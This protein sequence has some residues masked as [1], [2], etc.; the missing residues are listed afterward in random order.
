M[1][2]EEKNSIIGTK[3]IIVGISTIPYTVKEIWEHNGIT[4]CSFV[5]ITA[6]VNIET[7]KNP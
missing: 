1:T 6:V 7:I 3:K 2:L 5:E 4:L